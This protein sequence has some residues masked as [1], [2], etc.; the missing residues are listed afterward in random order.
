[1]PLNVIV[2]WHTL[3]DTSVNFRM[4]GTYMR[5][6]FQRGTL[7]IGLML[8]PMLFANLAHAAVVGGG[9]THITDGTFGSGE[10]NCAT[11]HRTVFPQVG[12]AGGATLYVDQGLQ[13]G[14]LD[15]FLMYD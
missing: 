6:L 10:W 9:C 4:R 12:A 2:I 5:N 8:A 15:L 13:T 3:N 14:F 1:M 11:V 7:R